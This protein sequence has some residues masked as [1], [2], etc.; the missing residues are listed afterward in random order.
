MTEISVASAKRTAMLLSI[1]QAV[2]GSA[3]PIAISMGALAGQYLLGPDKSL[4]TA[5][6]TGFNVGVALG[7]IPAAFLLRKLGGKLG[8]MSGALLTALGGACAAASLFQGSFWLFVCSL[9]ILGLGGAFVQQIRF[10]AADNSP[11]EFKAQAISW[12]LAGGIV[13]A[14]LGP[15]AV[16]QT[17]EAFAPVMFAGSYVAIIGFALAGMLVLIPITFAKVRT[18]AENQADRDDARP[19]REIVSQPKFIIALTC[20]VG[21]YALMSFVMTGAPL[22]MVACGHSV[23]N[24]TLGI[25]WH[26]L[27]MFGPSFFTGRL[28][29]RFGKEKIIATGLLTLI[30]CALV[31]MAGIQLW[32]FWLSL[33]LLGL[34][35][36]FGFIGSTALFT[37]TYRLSEK[38]KVQGFHDF[39]LFGSVALSSLF[40]GKVL[41][42]FGWNT[43][44]G[45][46]FP[47]VLICLAALAVL[48]LSAR[49]RAEV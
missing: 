25:Q 7:A 30:S 29:A 33:I 43:V 22:A 24:A 34:G 32:N 23:D 16:I 2:L 46:I 12:V 41:N 9:A 47:V 11:S 19:F 21:S 5:P 38:G 10:A 14:V 1:A 39:V 26:V 36:N 6:V 15:Q 40:A 18:A 45:I 48:T 8:F 27:A 4:A 20:A 44:N 17:R 3:A 49:K 13:S 35:W 37:E 31:A 42:S 28:I